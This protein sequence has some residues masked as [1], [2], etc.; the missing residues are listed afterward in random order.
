MQ[1]TSLSIAS[2]VDKIDRGEIR[3]PEIQRAYVWK[4]S[5]VAGLVDSLYRGYPS[6]S[7]LLWET[8]TP[9][10]EREAAIAGPN[11]TPMAKPLYLLDGQQRLTSLHRLFKGHEKTQVVFNAELERFQI[12][13][14]ATQR[15]ARWVKVQDVLDGS[16]TIFALVTRLRERASAIPADV[17]SARIERLKKIID[18]PYH[19]EIIQNL[20][21]PEVTDIFVRVNSKGRPLGAVDLALATL[22][23]RWPGIIDKLDAEAD[24]WK[25]VGY[26]R[27]DFAFMARCLAA[28]ATDVGTLNGFA[29]APLDALEQGWHRVR[30]GIEHAVALLQ[31]NVGMATSDLIPSM[32]AL[33]PLVVYLGNR[34]ES[35]MPADEASGL[36]YWLLGAFVLQRFSAAADT[37]IAQDAVAIK[38]GK[39]LPGLYSTLGVTGERLLVTEENLMG[40]GA[41]SPYFL[42]SYLAARR[43]GA[44]DWW[45]GTELSLMGEGGHKIEYHH[46][47]PR[48][49]INKDYSKAQV[50]DLSNLAFISA[51]ANRKISA[52]SPEEYFLELLEGDPS[53]LAYHLVPE[54]LLLRSSKSFLDFLRARRRLL[55]AGMTELLD[56]Y[57]P[58]TVQERA[59]SV[60]DPTSGESLSLSVYSQTYDPLDGVLVFE[61]SRDEQAWVLSIPMAQMEGV[62]E[63]LESGIASDITLPAGD[64]IASFEAEAEQIEIPVGPFLV[65]G[66][67]Q[68]WRKVLSREYDE[69]VIGLDELPSITPSPVWEG[70]LI[71][72]LVSMSD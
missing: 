15:D 35:P 51:K 52:R 67:R 36:I 39:G 48:A 18:Y 66:T 72:L 22:S 1:T 42:L 47:H 60:A 68:D 16:E 59:P 14:A 38:S 55:A 58:S 29:G 27:I 23:A 10:E 28:L 43:A 57:R 13:S 50:N 53:A 2:L 25:P 69:A 9:V 71:L 24:R 7:L 20:D 33:V 45:Y 63:D 32:N 11:A 26:S 37:A 46:I 34:N 61:A 62:M 44:K 49:T 21:Y 5:Q 3:L 56:S 64:V 30:K 41:G 8:D 6:G 12:Q 19:V 54:D 40:R 17:L 70:E 31:N 4:P 65:S